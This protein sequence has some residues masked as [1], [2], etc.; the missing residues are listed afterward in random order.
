MADPE[1]KGLTLTRSV[2]PTLSGAPDTQE[3]SADESA[4]RSLEQ[5][6]PGDDGDDSSEEAPR[7]LG[8]YR[9]LRE[10]GRGGMGVVYAAQDTR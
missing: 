5:S 2:H 10:L 3:Q 6:E 1:D 4:E 8:H 7:E 9:I